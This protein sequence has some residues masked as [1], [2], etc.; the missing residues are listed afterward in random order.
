MS[1]FDEG[2]LDLS[3]FGYWHQVLERYSRV[4]FK[5]L[6]SKKTR[7]AYLLLLDKQNSDERTHF[8]I[9]IVHIHNE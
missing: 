8:H 3:E 6:S 1:A 5:A 7:Y 4:L 9:S 2:L